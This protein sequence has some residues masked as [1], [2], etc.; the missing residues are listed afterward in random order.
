[1]SGYYSEGV[2]VPRDFADY[3]VTVDEADI[4]A[5]VSLSRKVD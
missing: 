1:M 5:G 4:P 3:T 2:D